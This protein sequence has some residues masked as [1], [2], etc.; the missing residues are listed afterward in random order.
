MEEREGEK[1]RGSSRVTGR[2]TSIHFFLSFFEFVV[3]ERARL[4]HVM[5]TLCAMKLRLDWPRVDAEHVKPALRV[6]N[7]VP[8]NLGGGS[9]H[10]A[11]RSKR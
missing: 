1:R 6:H 11:R 9:D 8:L 7:K 10:V 3:V 5:F 2:Q 4:S